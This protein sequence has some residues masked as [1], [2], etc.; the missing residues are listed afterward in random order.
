VI[1]KRYLTGGNGW[2]SQ[3]F[4]SS[5]ESVA[6]A[7]KMY[8]LLR[9]WLLGT[10]M[11]ARM[12]REFFLVN[13]VRAETEQDIES[14]FKSHIVTGPGKGFLRL[15]WEDIYAHITRGTPRTP[16]R[17]ALTRYIENKTIGYDPEGVLQ[18]AFSF[19]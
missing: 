3:V 14:S 18:M 17:D 2:Y 5:F 8:E 13:V 10:W 4:K 9:F 11:S 12:N 7:S 19:K 15:P 1:Q 16:S 6:V